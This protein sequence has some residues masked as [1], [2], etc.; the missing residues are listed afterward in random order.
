MKEISSS[1][2]IKSSASNVWKI[3]TEFRNYREWNP[4][5]VSAEGKPEFDNHIKITIQP[6]GS[7]KT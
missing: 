4:L 3:L 1:I 6:P 7:G 5:I 2:I